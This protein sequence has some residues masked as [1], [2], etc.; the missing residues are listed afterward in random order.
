[1][2]SVKVPTWVRRLFSIV[3]IV[4]GVS[5]LLFLT[6]RVIPSDPVRLLV[7]DSASAEVKAAIRA[8]L[9]LDDPLPEQYWRYLSGILHGDFGQSLRFQMPVSDLILDALPATIQLVIAAATVT[10]IMAFTLGLL[11]AIYPFTWIDTVCRT[12]AMGAT[13]TPPFFIAIVGILFLGF[14][15]GLVPISGRGD[16]PDLQHLILPAVVLGMRQAGSTALLVRSTM[17]DV[18]RTDYI[19]SARAR[20]LTER[21]VVGKYAFRNTLIPSVTDL[22][23]NL[24]D[25]I[26]AVVL[27][28]TIFAWPG[29]GRLVYLGII[30]N[31][32]ALLSGAV[33]TLLVYAIAVN[34]IV[35]ALYTVI[36]PR[37]RVAAR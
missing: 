2:T 19:R 9:G 32:F 23:V 13:A 14:Y 26:G 17:I 8:N 35:D 20:G 6:T 37:V 5:V 33:L 24:A 31:D 18:L 30:W 15:W 28:E 1:M 4:F 21:T 16:P 36:D 7:G 11:S 12:I 29:I 3:V 27:I 10:I 25:I 34:F 22:G